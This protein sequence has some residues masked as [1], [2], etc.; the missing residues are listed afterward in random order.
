M[1]GLTAYNTYYSV[2]LNVGLEPKLVAGTIKDPKFDTM[3]A[4]PLDVSSIYFQHKLLDMGE[5]FDKPVALFLTN[6][7]DEVLVWSS[8]F[9]SNWQKK[10]LEEIAAV[11][12]AQ[13]A[14]PIS[15]H[16][17]EKCA[18]YT[19]WVDEN[20][21]SK[22]TGVAIVLGPNQ[23]CPVLADGI[24]EM[25]VGE[26]EKVD[27]LSMSGTTTTMWRLKTAVWKHGKFGHPT[28]EMQSVF[29]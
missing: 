14:G 18:E 24:M 2:G 23:W 25:V 15:L 11:Y 3:I 12:K 29:Q 7:I 28:K 4:L 1:T 27:V 26:V 8:E 5:R 17:A 13:D 19:K 9:M 20:L 21:T 10:G 16:G 22:K 6:T